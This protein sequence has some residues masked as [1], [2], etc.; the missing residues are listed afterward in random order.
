MLGHQTVEGLAWN[1]CLF[2][3]VDHDSP[4]GIEDGE[5]VLL[6]ELIDDLIPRFVEREM[7]RQGVA[8]R[9]VFS[10]IGIKSVLGPFGKNE[11]SLDY[12]P[13]LPDVAGPLMVDQ[14]P[15]HVVRKNFVWVGALVKLMNDRQGE[16]RNIFAAIPKSR[17]VHSEHRESIE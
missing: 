3:R 9:V 12:V 17:Q 14:Q 6:F 7:D 10:A 8:L 4:A 11:Q 2:R 13:E 5:Q 15:E 1:I 16:Y